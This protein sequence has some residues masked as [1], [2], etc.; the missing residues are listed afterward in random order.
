MLTLKGNGNSLAPQYV[1]QG[2]AEWCLTL[3]QR[4]QTK[5]KYIYNKFVLRL[6]AQEPAKNG[7][8][9]TFGKLTPW[10]WLKLLCTYYLIHAVVEIRVRNWSTVFLKIR[11]FVGY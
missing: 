3:W 6:H 7:I 1:H 10:K 5:Q 8:Q 4:Q 11:H 9:D 2:D